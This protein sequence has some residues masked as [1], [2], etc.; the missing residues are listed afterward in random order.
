MEEEDISGKS[1]E[2]PPQSARKGR[3]KEKENLFEDAT[4]QELIDD[5]MWFF[6]KLPFNL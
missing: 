4:I 6:F 1:S 2:K 5:G 3:Q